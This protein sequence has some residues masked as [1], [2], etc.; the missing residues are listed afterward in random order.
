MKVLSS[1]PRFIISTKPRIPIMPIISTIGGLI[2]G[3]NLNSHVSL[4]T[5]FNK[6]SPS[7]VTITAMEFQKDPFSPRKL[8][9]TPKDSGTG[10][11]YKDYIVTNA[12]VV[13]DAFTIKITDINGIDHNANVVESDTVHDI[14]LLDIEYSKFTSLKKCNKPQEIGD[15]VIAIGNPFGFNNTL[16][17]GI[18]S[19]NNR[20]L[21]GNNKTPLVNL[22]QTDAAINPGNSGGPLISSKD[23]CIIGMNTAIVSPTGTNSGIG[24][25]IPISKVDQMINNISTPRIGITLL[26]ES[27]SEF[28]GIEG[29]I[30]ADVLENSPADNAGLIGTSRDEQGKPIVGDV[31]VEINNKK[32]KQNSD[33]Y[34]VLDKLKHND[35]IDLKVLKNNGIQD[36]R[37]KF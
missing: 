34:T 29:I 22:V 14:A 21:S 15:P 3:Y 35:F 18:I 8:L 28:L 20:A 4:A 6:V 32:C 27:F 10:F 24:F 7:V 9:E 37:I 5:I 30:I 23:G 36:I 2:M 26:P 11:F 13:S 25:A 17:S 12:H 19:G 33:L 1:K 16:T 31:I